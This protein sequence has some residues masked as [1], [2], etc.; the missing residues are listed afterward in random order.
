MQVGRSGY[1]YVYG[2][3]GWNQRKPGPT[4]D[5][6]T[7]GQLFKFAAPSVPTRARDLR[8]PATAAGDQLPKSC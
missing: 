8:Q 4:H 3:Q 7:G 2:N 5:L 6:H 1:F